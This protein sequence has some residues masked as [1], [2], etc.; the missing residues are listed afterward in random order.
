M[1]SSIALIFIIVL[2]LIST[3]LIFTKKDFKEDF[4]LPTQVAA[5]VPAQFNENGKKFYVGNE[6][7]E[8]PDEPI[9]SSDGYYKFRK[10]QL[11]YDGVWGE[12]CNLDGNGNMKCDWKEMSSD[13]PLQKDNLEY[14]T[15]KFFQEPKRLKMGEKIVSPPECPPTAKMSKCGLTYL[16]NNLANPPL[17]LDKPTQEDIIGYPPQDNELYWPYPG[18]VLSYID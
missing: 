12:N 16:E 10:M 13:C 11:L 15:N 17:Y 14:G 8:I 6:Q 5:N 2:I 7:P 18:V 9:V 4:K 1:I 3:V